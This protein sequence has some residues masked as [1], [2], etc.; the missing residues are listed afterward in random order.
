MNVAKKSTGGKTSYA[1]IVCECLI[2]LA[3][4]ASVAL[5]ANLKHQTEE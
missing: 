4:A 2:I 1:D 5:G 3:E